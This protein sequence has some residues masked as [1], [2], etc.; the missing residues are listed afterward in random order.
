MDELNKAGRI[1]G[2]EAQAIAA[3]WVTEE[4]PAIVPAQANAVVREVAVVLSRASAA[5]VA[6]R[7][8]QV[9]AAARVGEALAAAG[10][11]PGV[12]VR[13]AEAAEDEEDDVRVLG[14]KNRTMEQRNDAIVEG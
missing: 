10:P 14:L 3:V 8:P 7:A 5:A 9:R 4:E 2:A 6:R 1:S 12:A 11:G 13:E